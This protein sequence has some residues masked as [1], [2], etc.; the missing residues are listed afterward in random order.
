MKVLI[1]GKAEGSEGAGNTDFRT[2]LHD[3]V[4]YDPEKH[5]AVR[6]SH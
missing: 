1:P 2:K 6:S 5:I 3:I 4:A